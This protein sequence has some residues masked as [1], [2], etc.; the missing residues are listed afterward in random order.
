MKSFDQPSESA[1]RLTT[2][3]L[4]PAR[5]GG[6]WLTLMM[7]STRRKYGSSS[8]GVSSSRPKRS[9]HISSTDAGVRKQVPELIVVV[10]PTPRPSGRT[11]G[12]LPTVAVMP[13]SR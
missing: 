5:W 4:R 3:A 1:P 2:S 9:R 8:S 13:A 11:I 12:G 6:T 7:R 10:P